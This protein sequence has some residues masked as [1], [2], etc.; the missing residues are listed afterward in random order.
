MKTP[1]IT[2]LENVVGGAHARSDLRNQIDKGIKEGYAEGGVPGAVVLGFGRG[3]NF[4]YGRLK[5]GLVG[6][7]GQ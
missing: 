1:D 4:E 2:A 5:G 3:V 6:V 7:I